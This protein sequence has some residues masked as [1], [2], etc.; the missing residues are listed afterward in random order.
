MIS[1]IYS[2]LLPR[3]VLYG[4]CALIILGSMGCGDCRAAD[5]TFGYLDVTIEDISYRGN[6]QYRVDVVIHNRSGKAIALKEYSLSFFIQTEILGR[7]EELSAMRDGDNAITALP[8]RE[9]RHGSYIL[10]I[11]LT[12]P[13]LYINS[14]GDINM[15]FKYRMRVAGGPGAGHHSHSG[16]SSYWI[17]PKTN[18]WI[19]REGM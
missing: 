11:P 3:S 5:Q 17:T 8:P 2:V 14:E 16:E 4:W 9:A 13:S 15:M 6:N 1:V 19:L 12:I 10:S 7:W 18:S